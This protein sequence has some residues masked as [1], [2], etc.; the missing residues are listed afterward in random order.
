MMDVSG[1]QSAIDE[2]ARYC[3][4]NS[5]LCAI[6]RQHCPRDKFKPLARNLRFLRLIE[7]AIPRLAASIERCPPKA[8]ATRSNR[9]GCAKI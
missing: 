1:K 7:G 3:L 5:R 4:G 9:V 2:W 6:H 8:K